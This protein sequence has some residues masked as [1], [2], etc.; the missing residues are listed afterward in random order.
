[1]PD[2]FMQVKNRHVPQPSTKSEVKVNMPK[3]QAVKIQLNEVEE[4]A[5]EKICKKH[6]SGQQIVTRARI[7]LAANKG[8]SNHQIKRELNVSIN[9]VRLWRSRWQLLAPIP[10]TELSALEKLEDSPR[11]GAPARITADH[12]CQIEKLAC[13]IPEESGR[14]ISQW[15]NRELADEI[16]KKGIIET[17]S[18]RH[19][20]RLLKRSGYQASPN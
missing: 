11:S 17:I 10:F 7:I 12:R 6:K 13:E 4:A 19:V 15:T 20:G 5:L 8:L 3:L 14:P 1:V 2:I 9:T 16:V 18:P